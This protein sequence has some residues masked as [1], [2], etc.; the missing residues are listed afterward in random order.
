MPVFRTE[1]NS[2]P[3]SLGKPC[4]LEQLDEVEA[5]VDGSG[6]P[7]VGNGLAG[8][9]SPCDAEQFYHDWKTPNDSSERKQATRVKRSDST[10][11]LERIGRWVRLGSQYEY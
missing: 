10:R 7:I 4:T 3:P 1:D 5:Q 2:T 11:G 8:P 9:M 6:L